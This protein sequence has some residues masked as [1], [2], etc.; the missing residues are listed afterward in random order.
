MDQ[1]LLEIGGGPQQGRAVKGIQPGGPLGGLL[2]ATD[3]PLALERPPFT[4]RGVL[5]GSGGLILF[6]ERACAV[7]LARYFSE[8]CEDESCGRCTTCHGGSQRMVEILARMQSGDASERDLERLGVLDR[9]L[10]NSNCLHGQF[11]PYAVRAALRYFREEFLEHIQARRCRAQVCRGLVRHVVSDATHASLAEA[12]AIC[13]T[14]AVVQEDGAYRIDDAACIQCG[15]CR[16][17]APE[18]I[19]LQDRFPPAAAPAATA[20]ARTA[21]AL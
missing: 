3:L 8:F 10:Q 16:D 11:T 21:G 9:T 6:D 13:P 12:A 18:A 19:A 2:P 17:L 1:L 14:A 5:L 4:E 7:D 20:G 15:A